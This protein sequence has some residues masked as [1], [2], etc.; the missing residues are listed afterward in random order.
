MT[1]PGSQNVRWSNTGLP[2][3][4]PYVHH[5]LFYSHHSVKALHTFV[6]I[7]CPSSAAKKH[8]PK[9]SSLT[10][11]FQ[12]L[13]SFRA[14]LNLFLALTYPSQPASLSTQTELPRKASRGSTIVWNF[15]KTS[16]L[17]ITDPDMWRGRSEKN[18]GS[19]C[20]RAFKIVSNPP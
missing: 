1:C 17:K 13:N 5:L 11:N 19:V 14:H 3:P 12:K 15:S 7:W 9:F 20:L 18:L 4:A 6:V 10:V 8:E 16:S 2:M